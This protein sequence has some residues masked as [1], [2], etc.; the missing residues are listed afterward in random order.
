MTEKEEAVV[1]LNL[2][3][4]KCWLRK[5]LKNRKIEELV[6]EVTKIYE[7]NEAEKKEVGEIFKVLIE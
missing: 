5:E 2:M 6:D 3:F 7:M 1:K 4:I